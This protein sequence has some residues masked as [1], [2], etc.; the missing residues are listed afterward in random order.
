MLAEK[1]GAT[2]PVVVGNRLVGT[3]LTSTGEMTQGRAHLDR[4]VALYDPTQHRR[5]GLRFGQDIRVATLCVS[6]DGSLDAWL[7]ESRACGHRAGA[8]R[9]TRN[10]PSRHLLYASNH[11]LWIYLVRGNYTEVEHLAESQIRLVEEKGGDGG[12]ERR[13]N[14][15]QGLRVRADQQLGGEPK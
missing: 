13:C 1:Q 3:S 9:C 10:K 11:A 8:D 6:G 12:V 5:L 15:G 7:S 4:A 14:D 2:M